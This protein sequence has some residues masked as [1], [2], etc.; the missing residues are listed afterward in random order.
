MINTSRRAETLVGWMESLADRTRLRLIRVLE[1]QEL[2]VIE[3]CEILQLPQSTV[4]RHLKLLADQGWVHNRRDG[5]TRLYRTTLQELDPA[6][7]KLWVLA[8]EQTD[9]W[10]TVRQDELRLLRRIQQ[11]NVD[12]QAFFA[13]A[14]GKW[15]KIRRELYGDGFSATAMLALLPC[16]HIVV[17][18]GCGTGQIVAQLADHVGRAIGVDS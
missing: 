13:G 6:A 3:L 11:R 8:R 17:D 10:A 2:G 5:T 12:S 7:R 4:S 15:D 1:R 9:D 14:A 16:D 18:L